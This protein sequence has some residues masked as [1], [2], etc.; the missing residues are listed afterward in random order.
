M[1]KAKTTPKAAGESKDELAKKLEVLA[2]D[3]I[4]ENEAAEALEIAAELEALGA[5]EEIEATEVEITDGVAVKDI[6]KANVLDDVLVGFEYH[7]SQ[8]IAD[9]MNEYNWQASESLVEG[10]DVDVVATVKYWMGQGHTNRHI[11]IV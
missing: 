8:R 5:V 9:I 10:K 11:V 6:E 2:V 3:G 7:V 1:A 4:Q